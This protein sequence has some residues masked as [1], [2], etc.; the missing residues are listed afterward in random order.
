MLILLPASF[1][2]WTDGDTE[3]LMEPDLSDTSH[4]KFVDGRCSCCP[5][6]YHVDLDFLQY[7]ESMNN[8]D[9]LNSLKKLH[10]NKEELKRSLKSYLE[11]QELA[12]RS[13]ATGAG[14][15]PNVP[16][17]GGPLAPYDRSVVVGGSR[18]ILS[19]AANHGSDIT[20]DKKYTETIELRKV[21]HHRRHHE[22]DSGSS[23]SISSGPSSPTAMYSSPPDVKSQLHPPYGGRNLTETSMTTTTTSGTILP[24]QKLL[25][26]LEQQL[27]EIK[28]IPP[29]DQFQH[30]YVNSSGEFVHG[31][32]RFPTNDQDRT[33]P[34]NENINRF[35]GPNQPRPGEQDQR[36]PRHGEHKMRPGRGDQGVTTQGRSEVTTTYHTEIRHDENVKGGQGQHGVRLD[37][38]DMRFDRG[39]LGQENQGDSTEMTRISASTLQAIREQMAACLQRMHE[40]E[41]QIKTIPVLQV[42]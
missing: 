31:A 22:L 33:T 5:Y 28:P 42:F 30:T 10:P 14:V 40:M 38:V 12:R 29:T 25:L 36:E 35:S 15:P 39:E 23:L 9:Y 2:L 24:K 17:H 41:E 34:T 20:Y 8:G 7:L 6:G 16:L 21:Q 4:M 18:E 11:Q 1:C 37:Q 27:M 19:D 26:E 32:T 3:D 13:N